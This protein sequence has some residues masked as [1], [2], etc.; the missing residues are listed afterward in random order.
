MMFGITGGRRVAHH[1]REFAEAV[2]LT[3]GRNADNGH[4][5]VAPGQPIEAGQMSMAV[6][7][8]FGAG[9]G[10]GV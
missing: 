2:R 4:M 1:S 7:H 10:H 3:G 5:A 9:P 8:E 6:Q